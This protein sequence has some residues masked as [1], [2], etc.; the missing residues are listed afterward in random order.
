[1]KNKFKVEAKVDLENKLVTNLK[2]M[3][4]H[5]Y[6]VIKGQFL[7][8]MYVKNPEFKLTFEVNILNLML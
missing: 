2:K 5:I 8:K 7:K 3:S 4:I 1:M 6:L